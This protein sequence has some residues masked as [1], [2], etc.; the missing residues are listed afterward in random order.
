MTRA[1]YFMPAARWG[2][3]MGDS[4]LIDA[5]TGRCT[6]LSATATWA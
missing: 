2:Q 1:A 3:R 5:M 6:I 4:Q